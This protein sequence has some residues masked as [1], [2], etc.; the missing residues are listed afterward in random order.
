MA[1]TKIYIADDIDA[2]LREYGMR[3]FGYAKGSI[4]KAVE[5]AIVQWL[6]KIDKINSKINAIIDKAKKDNDVIAVFMFGSFAQRKYTFRDVDIAVLFKDGADYS[7]KL[8]EYMGI[9]D[10]V[11]DR[12][13]D[14]SAL[15]ILPLYIQS[16]VF[17]EG[18][19]LYSKDM[20]DLYKFN[21]R[22]IR[23]FDD[24]S[25]TYKAMVN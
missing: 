6:I 23:D 5:E 19:I 24:F 14:I 18:E 25:Y 4:S 20:K 12:T 9:A 16:K 1:E 21:V 22:E 7:A 10:S 11:E 2:K 17:N 3:R 15:N 13:L 8:F